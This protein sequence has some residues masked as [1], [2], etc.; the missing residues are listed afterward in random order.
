MSIR[1]IL[2]VAL[3]ALVSIFISACAK[4]DLRGWWKA[5]SDGKTYLVLEDAGGVKKGQFCSLDGEVW[6]YAV[7]ESGEIRPGTHTIGCPNEVGFK[8]DPAVEYHFNY[9]GP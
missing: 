2:R 7:G 4:H 6:P 1:S 3:L 9:W 8:A 5:S